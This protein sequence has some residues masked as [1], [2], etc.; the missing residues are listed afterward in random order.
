MGIEC[1]P[2]AT[3]LAGDRG[4]EIDDYF[5]CYLTIENVLSGAENLLS[6]T[7]KVLSGCQ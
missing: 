5:G 6:G 1:M 2:A 3:E 4:D 7:K